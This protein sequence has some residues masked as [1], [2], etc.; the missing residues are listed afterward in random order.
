ML[1]II[2]R[3][4][5]QKPD[6][7]DDDLRMICHQAHIAPSNIRLILGKRN[8]SHNKYASCPSGS[9]KLD[10]RTVVV[11]IAR[12]TLRDDFRFVLAHEI[13]HLKAHLE[14]KPIESIRR[15]TTKDYGE[16]KPTAFALNV[17]NCYPASPYRVKRYLNH[18]SQGY[19]LHR[20]EEVDNDLPI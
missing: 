7:V 11:R 15:L 9:Y 16:C 3:S 12:G 2:N 8:R 6:Y 20:L 18:K 4:K 10:F 19:N 13:G 14:A 17:C 1:D 5:L